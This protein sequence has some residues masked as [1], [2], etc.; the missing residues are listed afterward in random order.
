MCSVQERRRRAALLNAEP[1]LEGDAV[2]PRIF[3]KFHA[4]GRVSGWL[5]HSHCTA[6]R[7]RT[8][9]ATSASVRFRFSVELTSARNLPRAALLR[10][11][12]APQL[13]K[14]GPLF[15]RFPK[16]CKR[17][18]EQVALGQLAR[19]SE[20]RR[21]SRSS[22]RRPCEAYLAMPTFQTLPDLLGMN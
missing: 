16:E 15:Q 10:N 7:S 13:E 1:F 8:S 3:Q 14:Q 4:P 12:P 18:I 17:D 5:Q 9:W 19:T 20:M 11:R 2:R 22:S 6:C 21:S